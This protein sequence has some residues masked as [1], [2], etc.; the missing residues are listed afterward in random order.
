MSDY[1]K[2]AERIA[3]TF[4]D[5]MAFMLPKYQWHYFVRKWRIDN[6]QI[7]I[8][9]ILA[10]YQMLSMRGYNKVLRVGDREF[11]ARDSRRILAKRSGA[12]EKLAARKE[13]FSKEPEQLF[14]YS[15]L[16]YMF[17]L[18]TFFLHENEKVRDDF[19]RA[20]AEI[21]KQDFRKWLFDPKM[22]DVNSAGTSN[23]TYYL[24]FLGI[25]DYEAEM[26]ESVKK[27]WDSKRAESGFD[28]NNK[29]YGYT[30]LILAATY[31]YQRLLDPQKFEWVLTF[32][33]ENIGKVIKGTN[34]DIIAEVG[35]V[36]RLCGLHTHEVVNKSRE[37]IVSVFD[38]EGGFVP[39]EGTRTGLAKLEHRNILAI[40]L[41]SDW[42]KLNL[43]PN[44]NIY[45]KHRKA[46][47]FLPQ[48]GIFL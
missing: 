37:H 12:T 35:L 24:Q 25:H 46:D 39:R 20:S 29:I 44:L 36:F 32:F 1:N 26:I 42:S 5:N 8:Q 23:Y 40:M 7:Y 13:L 14:Y 31:Y 4:E 18:K 34:A 22:I 47:F 30:H 6:D 21:K 19:K 33:E 43:G 48:K 11:V 15:L 41:L 38:K 45:I 16:Q 17:Y 9:P 10:S 3:E 2:I 28:F 27:Y